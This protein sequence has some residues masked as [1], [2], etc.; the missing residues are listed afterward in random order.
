MTTETLKQLQRN[1]NKT[2]LAQEV[3]KLRAQVKR[4]EAQD[5]NIREAG[6]R[7]DKDALSNINALSPEEMAASM[8]SLGVNV[9]NTLQQVT[10]EIIQGRNTLADLDRACNAKKAELENLFGQEVLA[11]SIGNL[12]ADLDAKKKE[13][14]AAEAELDEEKTRREAAEA[15]RKAE[16][17]IQFQKDCTQAQADWAYKFAKEKREQQDAFNQQLQT[18]RRAFD[19]EQRVKDREQQDAEADLQKRQLAIAEKENEAEALEATLKA[20][21][22]KEK[23]TVTGAMKREHEHAMAIAQTNANTAAQIAASTIKTQEEQMLKQQ[24]EIE[25]LKARMSE[26]QEKNTELAKS[27]L[28][29][30]SHQ[31]ALD[32]VMRSGGNDGQGKT[33]RGKA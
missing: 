3:F 25:A 21:F 24:A 5:P 18:E 17:D 9:N 7:A 11:R 6:E 1:Y 28:E 2:E 15:R 22:D 19:D 8:T 20:K 10:S 23:H 32:A 29:S 30:A 31:F 4:D 27:A 12:L 26:V 14:K 13:A 16:W 33:T